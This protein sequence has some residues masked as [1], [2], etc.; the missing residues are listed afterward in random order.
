MPIAR[1]RGRHNAGPKLNPTSKK[2]STNTKMTSY[3][4]INSYRTSSSHGFG[5]TWKTYRLSKELRKK[6]LKDGLPVRDCCG[7]DGSPVFSTMGI[8]AATPAER[9]ELKKEEADA[10]CEIAAYE[11]EASGDCKGKICFTR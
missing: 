4:S 10:G 5:N 2:M 6:L 7:M 3:I 9:R 8:A 1:G 11:V